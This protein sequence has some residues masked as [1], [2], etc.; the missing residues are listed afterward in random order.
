MHSEGVFAILSLDGCDIMISCYSK[1]VHFFSPSVNAADFMNEYRRGGPSVTALQ[2][3]S[4]NLPLPAIPS[5]AIRKTPATYANGP[6][7][8]TELSCPC[9]THSHKF[10][11]GRRNLETLGGSFTGNVARRNQL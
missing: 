5:T 10:L 4:A 2:S 8:Q 9:I 3:I 7:E 1:H 11:A 6:G